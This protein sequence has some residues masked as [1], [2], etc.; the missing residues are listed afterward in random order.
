LI[1]W[2][3]VIAANASSKTARYEMGRFHNP[4]LCES[5][6]SQNAFRSARSPMRIGKL[7]SPRGITEGRA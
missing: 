7:S 4:A 5:T 2:R 6:R 1:Q 3:H